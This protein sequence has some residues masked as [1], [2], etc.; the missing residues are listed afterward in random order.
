MNLSHVDDEFTGG[1]GLKATARADPSRGPD[2]DELHM[3]GEGLCGGRG[4]STRGAA[5]GALGIVVKVLAHAFSSAGAA[6]GA[7]IG[8][9][10][11]AGF[12]ARFDFF[13]FD[14]ARSRPTRLCFRGV[15]AARGM[16]VSA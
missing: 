2:V 13:A 5:P 11:V 15:A 16:A 12:A 1:C 4:E 9:C 7:A 6:C 8:A 10:S 14:D 3:C